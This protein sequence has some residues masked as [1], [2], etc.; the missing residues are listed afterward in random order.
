MS[1]NA[2]L[3]ALAVVAGAI[4]SPAAPA[5]PPVAAQEQPAGGNGSVECTTAAGVLGYGDPAF[6]DDFTTF[7]EQRW[8]A[9]SGPSEHQEGRF[10]ASGGGRRLR[11]QI[12]VADGILTITG[13]PNGDTAGM[14]TERS[15]LQQYGLWEARVKLPANA[16]DYHSVLLLMAGGQELDFVEAMEPTGRQVGGFLHLAS[17]RD[18]GR[19][20]LQDNDWHN[21]A[22]E[23]T[24]ERIRL[25]LDGHVWRE[26]AA[27]S[28][29]EIPTGEASMS[30]QLD[31][32]P[33]DPGDTG[34]AALAV[35]WVRV[36]AAR[37]GDAAAGATPG[38]ADRC[39]NG[40]SRATSGPSP[41][42]PS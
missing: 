28:R 20:T 23:W 21:W 14:S 32:F 29:V 27:S 24:P 10:E 19:V 31:W 13:L 42:W 26:V 40:A 2:L 1:R 30:I 15:H 25:Y 34:T 38:C 36:Y 11:E 8:M 4:A 39:A 6:S 33:D 22:V 18:Q 16:V 37:A 3:A 5:A 35:D 9:Y 7:D 41:E 17:G 12:T